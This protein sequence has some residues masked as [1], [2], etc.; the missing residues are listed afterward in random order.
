MKKSAKQEF[1]SQ[2]IKKVMNEGIRGKKVSPKQAQAVAFS[3][4]NR[5]N[6]FLLNKLEA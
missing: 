2:K 3:Y 5:G 6:K 1:I 4:A